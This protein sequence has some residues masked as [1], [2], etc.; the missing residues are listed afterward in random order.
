MERPKSS[1]LVVLRWSRDSTGC[2]QDW[3]SSHHGSARLLLTERPALMLSRAFSYRTVWRVQLTIGN[4]PPRTV[5]EI[6]SSL[7]VVPGHR[8]QSLAVHH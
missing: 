4:D 5:E 1:V 3:L 2:L 8:S 6:N 7:Q